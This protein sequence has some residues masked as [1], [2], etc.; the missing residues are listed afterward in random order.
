MP[1]LMAGRAARDSIMA[2]NWDEWRWRR[3]GDGGKL[4]SVRASR[5]RADLLA[6]AVLALAQKHVTGVCSPAPLR[7]IR[8]VASSTTF[9]ILDIYRVSLYAAT[10]IAIKSDN[11]RVQK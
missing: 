2:R 6:L 4:L 3:P 11:L 7:R 10:Y 9:S 5:C 1:A 8:D